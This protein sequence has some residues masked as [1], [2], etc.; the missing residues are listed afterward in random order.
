MTKKKK[1]LW[2]L[3]IPVIVLWILSW[4][5]YG[6]PS[7]Q[8]EYGVSFSRFHSDELK[9]DWKQTYSALLNDLGVKN[10]RFSAHWSLTEP[11][12][13]QFNFSE[14]DYQMDQARAQNASVILAVG[15]RLPGW[16]ECHEPDWALNLDK[17]EKQE[18]I[19]EY[20]EKVVQRYKNYPNLV[21]WQ[22]ENEPFLTFFSRSACGELD[23]DFL[24]KEIDWVKRLDP[25]RPVMVTDSGEF[26][27]WFQAYRRGD[28][29]G[30]SLYLYIWNRRFGP[31]RYPVIPAFFKIKH[32]LVRLFLPDKPA[33]IIE[34]SSEPWLLAPIVNTPLEVQLEQMGIDRF[35]RMIDFSSKTGFDKIYLWG[36][37]WW[38]WLK[39]QGHLEHWERAK[40]IFAPPGSL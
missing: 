19:L 37:E 5:W 8:I 40:E 2:I 24:E 39:Q 7:K 38:Y 26:G 11:K 16:P 28:V 21:Y 14:M 9:L 27:N 29:F 10:F 33:M 17:K 6:E 22:V 12:N 25:L 36:A 34:L 23:K 30:T 13:N 15:R 1:A 3:I 31:L 18:E 4:D 20:I 35:N 32:N